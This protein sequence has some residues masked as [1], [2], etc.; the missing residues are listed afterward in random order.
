MLDL[1]T[2]ASGPVL[3]V[4]QGRPAFLGTKHVVSSTHYLATMAGLRMFAL[5][6]NAADAGVA[7]GIALNVLERHM[8]DFGGV[9]PIMFFRPGMPRPETIAGVGCWPRRLT[10]ERFLERYGGDMPLGA[11]RYVTPAAPDAWLTALARYG[12]LTLREV[13]APACDLCDG[14]PVYD[15]LARSIA[16]LAPRLREWPASAR[17]FLPNGR[18]PQVGEVLV[19]RELGGV[20]RRLIDVENGARQRGREAA[21][22][23]ARDEIYRGEIAR[24][25]AAH[26][27]RTGSELDA[28]DLAAY[29]VAIGPPVS[30]R[31]R[32]VEVH[33]CGP[34]SQGPLLPMVLN[35]RSPEIHGGMKD[36]RG[37]RGTFR[38]PPPARRRPIRPSCARWTPTAT[39]FARRR[40]TPA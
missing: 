34:W 20:F 28:E 23:A 19:Q 16:T 26:A 37:L 14:F 7:A 5:G 6:G 10:L 31:Y 9:A 27:E 39:P 29:R 24:E 22:G 30:S 15:R 18:P 11:P 21:I 25:L 40:P 1:M 33:A 4:T 35:F 12:R 2:G 32:D 8:T 13:L 36:A 17:V 3:A 38:L